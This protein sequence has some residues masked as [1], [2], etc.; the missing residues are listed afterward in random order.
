MSLLDDLP[1]WFEKKPLVLLRFEDGF[2]QSLLVSRRGVAHFTFARPHG[3]FEDLKLPTLCL[4]EMPQGATRKYY[5]GVVKS[6]AAV[7]TFD[8]RL[9]VTALK[10]LNL[11]SFDSLEA[12]LV[13]SNFQTAFRQK[14]G[15]AK[16][17]SCLSPKLSVAIINALS[18]DPQNKSAIESAA[19]NVPRLR[20]I[21]GAEWEQLDAIRTAI[22]AFG[23][24]KTDFPVSVDVADG[25]DSTLNFLDTNEAHVLE[26]NVIATD[27]SV[28]PGFDLVDRHVTGRAVFMRGDQRLDV[29]TANKGPLEI[30][31]GVDLI[32]INQTAGN[33]VMIQYKMLEQHVDPVTAKADWLCRLDQQ[34]RDEMA[35]MK[36]LPI[37]G[38]IDDY[39]LSRN[40]FF[41]KFVHRK[42]DG[43]SHHSCIISL[44][45]LNQLLLSPKCK[46]PKDGV[47]V[48]FD[49][50]DG[51]YLRETDLIGLIKSGYI[52]THRI[53]T[54]ALKLLI[55]AV[56]EG[57]RALVLAWQKRVQK[58][59]AEIPA[60]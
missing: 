6:K 18:N 51:V 50:L 31:L 49:S 23:L 53:E 21:S 34:F 45:H 38:T 41:F 35:R 36:I 33:T 59:L 16:L 28:I 56:S 9:T 12:S 8:S 24:S 52:G 26:D 7:T 30:M 1:K 60:G 32:Y 46:G 22:A 58:E 2:E 54:D 4:A 11:P 40:P 39:R 43:E 42:G 5:V 27:A 25:S 37:A 15:S 29:Y 47:R 48:S 14:L 17:A 13:G 3:A 44:D 20:Q 55:Q 19:F 10:V 57:K